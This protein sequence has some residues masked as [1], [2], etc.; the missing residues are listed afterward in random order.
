MKIIFQWSFVMLALLTFACQPSAQNQVQAKKGKGF[1]I[2]MNGDT[3]PTLVKSNR[4]WK[5]ILDPFQY[6]VMREEATERAFT[7]Q[8][9]YNKEK[10]I[11]TCGACDL[12]LFHSKSK[13]ESG[14]GWPS[15]YEPIN[16]YNVEERIDNTLGITRIE[17]ICGRCKGH[18]GHVFDDGPKPTGLRY[19]INSVALDFVPKSSSIFDQ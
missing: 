8:L 12:P 6:E 11:Y 5:K 17:V 1:Y 9:L 18:L 4:E 14:S 15:Y 10:G 2:D 3:V 7:G 16:E 19:C 13:F